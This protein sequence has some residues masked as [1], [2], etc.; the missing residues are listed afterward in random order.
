MLVSYFTKSSI[1][2]TRKN[3][4]LQKQFSVFSKLKDHI[5]NI[6]PTNAQKDI[7]FNEEYEKLKIQYGIPDQISKNERKILMRKAQEQEQIEDKFKVL[8][9]IPTEV[10]SKFLLLKFNY[11][12][13]IK[14]I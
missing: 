2:F 8:K 13:N 1:K 3:T 5:K 6:I 4:F 14:G 9:S 7:K 10:I 11:I 12:K